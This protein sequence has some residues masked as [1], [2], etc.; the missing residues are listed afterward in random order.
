MVVPVRPIGSAPGSSES[1]D[2]RRVGALRRSASSWPRARSF[3]LHPRY[4]RTLAA[5]TIVLALGLRIAEVQRTP[6]HPVGDARSYLVLASQIAG[7]GDYASSGPGAGGSRSASAYFPPALPYLLAAVD[8]ID[9]HAT[10]AGAA[11]APA[12]LTEALIGTAIVVLIGLVALECFGESVALLALVIAAIYPVFVELSTVIVAE[13]LLVA[14]ELGAVWCTL[15][16]RRSRHAGWTVATGV[17]IG[18]AALAHVNGLLLALPLGVGLAQL[19]GVGGPRRTGPVMMLCAV[20]VTLAPWLIRDA[21][22]LHRFVPISDQTGFTLAGTYNP[23]S[24]AA[25]DPPDTWLPYTR[26]RADLDIARAASSFTE[27]ELGARLTSRSLSYIRDHPLAPLEVAYHNTLRLLELEG[28]H[29]WRASAAA[30]GI[31]GGT[32]QTG[33]VGFWLLCALALAGACTRLARRAPVWI[34]AVPL[35]MGLSVVLTDA[36]T[37]RLRETIDPF[38][39]LLAACALASWAGALRGVAAADE[40]VDPGPDTSADLPAVS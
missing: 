29:A 28:S 9:G 37:P 10:A 30:I 21:V 15:R 1:T 13:N 20:A 2:T 8:E 25:H 7:T 19:P 31:N 35:L 6:Y 3:A 14:F 39:V 17:M 33:V 23:T 22:V 38:L 32:A 26:I 40:P 27:P 12:R 11:V 5:V 36:Q 4:A 18:L 24:A 34:W 16:A